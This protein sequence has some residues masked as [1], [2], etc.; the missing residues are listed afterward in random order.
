MSRIR[1]ASKFYPP[2]PTPYSISAI[3]PWRPRLC[4]YSSQDVRHDHPT[5]RFYQKA[6]DHF[7]Y[8]KIGAHGGLDCKIFIVSSEYLIGRSPNHRS[9][10]RRAM[11]PTRGGSKLARTCRSSLALLI[12]TLKLKRRLPKKACETLNHRVLMGPPTSGVWKF[13]RKNNAKDQDADVG[14]LRDKTNDAGR[15]EAKEAAKKNRRR[16]KTTA[17]IGPTC[18]QGRDLKVPAVQL[19][20]HESESGDVEGGPLLRRIV[21]Q[22]RFTERE[23]AEVT[24]DLATALKF[25]HKKGI[26]HRDLKPE[27][28]LCVSRTS[29]SPVKLCDLDLGSGVRF[30]PVGPLSTPR[31]NSPVGSAEYMAP[32]V[33]EVFVTDSPTASYDK[34]C[35][36]W[37]LGVVVYILLSGYAPF[38]GRSCQE[39]R[40]SVSAMLC[41]PETRLVVG[42]SRIENGKSWAYGV[43]GFECRNS[44][45]RSFPIAVNGLRILDTYGNVQRSN[46]RKSTSPS[47]GAIMLENVLKIILNTDEWT[48]VSK[49]ESGDSRS[50]FEERRSVETREALSRLFDQLL[51]DIYCHNLPTRPD[52]QDGNCPNRRSSDSTLSEFYQKTARS[53][54]L[55]RQKSCP[56]ALG[57]LIVPN[58]ITSRPALP[59]RKISDVNVEIAGFD[60]TIITQ[61]SPL[62]LSEFIEETVL[63]ENKLKLLPLSRIADIHRD[64]ELQVSTIGKELVDELERK[65]NLNL[66]QDGLCE[67]VTASLQ[68]ISSKTSDDAKVKFSLTPATHDQSGFQEWARAMR[69]VARLPDGVPTHFRKNLWLSLAERHLHTKGVNWSQTERRLFS[70]TTTSEDKELSVQIVKD[71]HRTGC[72]LFCGATGQHNQAVLKRVLLAYARWNKNVGYCQGLNMLAALILQVMQGSQSATVKVMIYLI[73]GVLPESYFANNLRGLSVDMAVFRDLLRL[74]LPELSKH[75]D[76]LQQDSKDSGT[77]YEPPLCDV[78][79]MQW[80]LTLFSNCLPQNTVLRVW[81]LVF[82]EGDQVLLRTALA[83]WQA[84]SDRMMS[85]RSADEFYSIMAVLTREMMEFGLME[86]NSLIKAIDNMNVPEV[87]DLREKYIYNISPWAVGTVAKMGVKLLYSDHGSP[88]HDDASYRENRDQ[89]MTPFSNH[90]DR[91]KIA[92]DISAL[93]R[94]YWK[95]RERQRQAHII[96]SGGGTSRSPSSSASSSSSSTELCDSS[97]SDEKSEGDALEKIKGKG[98]GKCHLPD[99]DLGDLVDERVAICHPKENSKAEESDPRGQSGDRAFSE[100]VAHLKEV[101]D[102]MEDEV[103]TIDRNSMAKETRSC[104]SNSLLAKTFAH[105][106]S[107]HDV[108]VSK[109]SEGRFGNE[110]SDSQST[111]KDVRELSEPHELDDSQNFSIDVEKV[112]N[113]RSGSPDLDEASYSTVDAARWGSIDRDRTE[114]PVVSSYSSIT[115]MDSA[116]LD[117]GEV[118]R[119]KKDPGMRKAPSS[120]VLEDKGYPKEGHQFPIS[121]YSSI[122]LGGLG[123]MVGNPEFRSSSLSSMQLGSVE[124]SSTY[125]SLSSLP[126][127]ETTL[128]SDWSRKPAEDPNSTAADQS[129]RHADS[130]LTSPEKSKTAGEDRSKRR[131]SE[132]AL[133]QILQENSQILHRIHQAHKIDSPDEPEDIKDIRRRYCYRQSSSLDSPKTTTD[134]NFRPPSSLSRDLTIK[135]VFQLGYPYFKF[136]PPISIFEKTLPGAEIISYGMK[137]ASTSCS[138]A[139]INGAWSTADC[140]SASETLCPAQRTTHS[141]KVQGRCSYILQTPRP[142]DVTLLGFAT[143]RRALATTSGKMPLIFKVSTAQGTDSDATDRV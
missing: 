140:S 34:R 112:L 41:F 119:A 24:R 75:L 94:Q 107:S 40:Q 22:E 8:G 53:V 141:H 4:K 83:I 42:A 89:K 26:A 10:P 18:F 29:L 45:S 51:S 58:A 85:V 91:E 106:L 1:D 122:Q 143:S 77:S 7:N 135:L 130:P 36:L 32:E 68:A 142:E 128:S 117:R 124:A 78:F 115:R 127:D 50:S 136:V 27:N 38:W 79:T 104:P 125:S 63:C 25:L 131:K 98:L 121:S 81:D 44:S 110:N 97:D 129:Q 138:A 92:L 64:L 123:G 2:P 95:L 6:C 84:L 61:L 15:K 65:D 46:W 28:I 139:T 90:P 54:H 20:D 118:P 137:E 31:L 80:F 111:P 33:V 134:G 17:S 109:A 48:E 16:K 67:I 11:P 12:D 102:P 5:P 73:E 56:G 76:H 9:C 60:T 62:E 113:T 49:I 116:E 108:N 59:V 101:T 70:D 55:N 71:L 39:D 120:S 88:N 103:V 37:S 13:F 114:N 47:I 82:L 74:K 133:L 99:D 3:P 21:E 86:P 96:L 105:D 72:S 66:E 57:S 43:K 23:A 52:S 19:N 14:I 93:K 126:K 69:M 100:D 87:G 30:S 35:D 132:I